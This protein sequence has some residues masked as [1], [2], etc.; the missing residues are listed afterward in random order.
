MLAG[1]VGEGCVG[2]VTLMVTCTWLQLT[3]LIFVAQIGHSHHVEAIYISGNES[4]ERMFAG[5]ECWLLRVW[6]Y[7]DLPVCS[8]WLQVHLGSIWKSK[9]LQKWKYCRH[10][11]QMNTIWV[12]INLTFITWLIF[13]LFL[14]KCTYSYNEYA[15]LWIYYPS[16]LFIKLPDNRYNMHLKRKNSLC[17]WAGRDKVQLTTYSIHT[18]YVK[19]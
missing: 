12:Y 15:W 6:S 18:N 11:Q 3:F 7:L 19:V 4:S 2:G 9:L 14:L 8:L 16:G 10:V 5:Q 13:R 17:W 1:R